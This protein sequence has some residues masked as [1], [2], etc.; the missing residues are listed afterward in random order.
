LEQNEVDGA[1]VVLGG[2]GVDGFATGDEVGDGGF[3]EFFDGKL[4]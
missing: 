1:V 2:V 3:V 4:P